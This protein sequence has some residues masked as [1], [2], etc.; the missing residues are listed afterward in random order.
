MTRLHTPLVLAAPQ[1]LPL[2]PRN[3]P[4]VAAI[5][6]ALLALPFVA[7][8]DVYEGFG[9][10][11]GPRA[12]PWAGGSGFLDGSGPG[13]SNGW[14][15]TGA[16][17]PGSLLD[18]SGTLA[19]SGNQLQ[20]TTANFKFDTQRRLQQTMGVS[21]TD[22]WLGWLQRAS[23]TGSAFHGLLLAEPSGTGTY[24]IG[25]PGFGPADGTYAISKAGD[26]MNAASSGVAVA[27]NRTVFLVAH[28]QF[29]DGN[30]VATLFVNPTPGA[31]EP[32]GG[33]V[34]QNFDMP[35]INP[36]ADFTGMTSNTPTTIS[37]DELRVGATYA[38]VA[39]VAPEPAGALLFAGAT[40]LLT[41]RRR[42]DPAVAQRHPPLHSAG[43]A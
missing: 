10:P 30:D 39:P 14:T 7:R 17:A 2:T 23:T 43:A 25:E 22:V 34:Y 12:A 26:D 15:S 31:A 4:T 9:Y 28:L 32:T 16:I 38:A 19:V 40:A 42:R 11:T 35:V 27:A 24:F 1:P 8:A 41:C 18:P 36:V 13:V 29:R 6:L 5:G 21:G 20:V 37:F 3:R 33:A